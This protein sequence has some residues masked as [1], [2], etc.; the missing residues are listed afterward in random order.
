MAT[1]SKKGRLVVI[2]GC[3]SCGKSQEMLRL[4]RRAELAHRS[5]QVYVPTLDTR[6]GAAAT[7]RDG[8]SRSA[9]TVADIAEFVRC[10]EFGLAA[11]A[12]V[13]AFDEAQFF[14][15]GIVQAVNILVDIG[16]DVVVAGLDT[17]FRGEPFG[18]MPQLLALADEV[19]KLDA[20]CVVCGAS[21]TRTQRLIGGQPAPYNAPTIVVDDGHGGERY[22]A[23]CRDCHEVPKNS[24]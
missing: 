1:T 15:V 22:E 3:M 2:S 20:V 14:G 17:D 16:I 11:S 18:A 6:S 4:L 19:R 10:T 7:S 8:H 13:V 21:A 23:R 12:D 24:P 9:T 5:V